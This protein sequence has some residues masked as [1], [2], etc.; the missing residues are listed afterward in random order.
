MHI[1]THVQ[2]RHSFRTE[3]QSTRGMSCLQTTIYSIGKYDIFAILEYI[4]VKNTL[5][6]IKFAC[7]SYTT[8]FC[9]HFIMD[10]PIC[11]WIASIYTIHCLLKLLRKV[12]LHRYFLKGK[13]KK[14]DLDAFCSGS[15]FLLE[16]LSCAG[17]LLSHQIPG[18][19][20]ARKQNNL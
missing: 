10:I 8:E 2:E 9:C 13:K 12:I 3:R 6:Y 16:I 1:A 15:C 11:Y 4:K 18:L 7:F 19:L 17:E 5:S 20:G 14:T